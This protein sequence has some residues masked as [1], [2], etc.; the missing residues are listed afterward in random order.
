MLTFAL[1]VW[2]EVSSD[3]SEQFE[4]NLGVG[5]LDSEVGTQVLGESRVLDSQQSSLLSAWEVGLQEFL[6][7]WSDFT[8]KESF[9]D[10]N[11][12]FLVREGGEGLKISET[13]WKSFYL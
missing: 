9:H 6:D 5:T 7:K 11:G 13:F 12:G 1:D 4:D 2:I 8:F 10:F 3:S